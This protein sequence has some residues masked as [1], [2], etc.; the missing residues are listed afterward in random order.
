VLDSFLK[1]TLKS[2]LAATDCLF[3][4]KSSI[5]VASGEIKWMELNA[6]I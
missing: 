1:E 2:G 4:P 5:D 3:G 6:R